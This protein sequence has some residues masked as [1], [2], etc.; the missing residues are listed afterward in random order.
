MDTTLLFYGSMA[1]G[2]LVGLLVLG[3]VWSTHRRKQH[4]T[5]T[6]ST[7]PSAQATTTTYQLSGLNWMIAST[8]RSVA[9]II[10]LEMSTATLLAVILSVL[11]AVA[12]LVLLSWSAMHNLAVSAV[13]GLATLVLGVLIENISINSLKNIR[14]TGEAIRATEEDYYQQ[15]AAHLNQQFQ[16]AVQ[17]FGQQPHYQSLTREQ[18]RDLQRARKEQQRVLSDLERQQKTLLKQR[19]RQARRTRLHAIPFAI[20]GVGFSATAGGLFWHQV[21]SALDL[22]L[23]LAIST[24]FALAVSVTFIQS[25]LFKHAQG[26]SIKEAM[27]TNEMQTELFRQQAEDIVMETTIEALEGVRND[28]TAMSDVQ[29]TVKKEIK[30]TIKTLTARAASRLVRVEEVPDKT[31][32][33]LLPDRTGHD[34][35]ADSKRRR[36][37]RTPKTGQQTDGQDTIVDSTTADRTGHHQTGH[38]QTGQGTPD[39]P[40]RTGHWTRPLTGQDSED[41]TGDTG[42]DTPQGQDSGHRTRTPRQVNR[43]AGSGHETGQDN[44]TRVSDYLTGHPGA[45]Q[46][47]IAHALD[48]STKTVQRCLS[49][50]VKAAG[51]PDAGGDL[52]DL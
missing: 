28:P 32:S 26:E 21:L 45:R 2:G 42:Q 40:T 6:G 30:A 50:L 19:T 35:T 33:K 4:A 27:R 48:I 12:G 7:S 49:R 36:Q 29:H 39:R 13:A 52:P 20:I 25:E 24:M 17:Q 18:A 23:N 31:G 34:R 41:E 5:Q 38:H 14:Q 37:D 1:L 47:D 51:T 43:T 11:C 10:G 9:Q 22:S 16:Q 44:L 8:H 46:V 3:H 15:H